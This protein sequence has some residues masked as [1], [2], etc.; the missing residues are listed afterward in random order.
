[1]ALMDVP[2]LGPKAF[3][4]CAGFLRITGGTDP[5]DASAVHPEAYPVVR[6]ILTA[7]G[8]EI[9]RLM[10][11]SAQ[12][13]A[14]DPADFADDRFGVPTVTDILAELDKPGRDPRP[15]FTA[16]AFADGV[17]KIGDLRPGMVL[18]GTVTNVAAFGAF[19]DVGVG[20]DGLVHVSAMSER[21]V[22]DPHEIVRSGQ[23]VRVKVMEVDLERQRIG[24]SLRLT[25]EPGAPARRPGGQGRKNNGEARAQGGGRNRGGKAGAAGR[26]APWTGP[27]ARARRRAGRRR[28]ARW[29]MRCGVPGSADF[30]SA[31]DLWH[32]GVVARRG[33]RP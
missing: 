18:E 1:R 29:P 26:G 8:T 15:E 11:A 17:D 4:Q 3:E 33:R 7:T 12:L 9:D 2:R 25:D 13:A 5:L 22:S 6:R 16:A 30:P 20:Q 27:G 14:L 24:L 31:P 28:R 10:G 19:V 23:V 21:F 32:H